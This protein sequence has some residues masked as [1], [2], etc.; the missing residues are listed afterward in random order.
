VPEEETSWYIL[1]EILT[2]V[3]IQTETV[4]STQNYLG[5]DQKPKNYAWLAKDGVS[6]VWKGRIRLVD[7]DRD[8]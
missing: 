1:M 4:G 3:N 5:I 7:D 6:I 2:L 8:F